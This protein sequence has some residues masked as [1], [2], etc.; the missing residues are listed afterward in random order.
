MMIGRVADEPLSC[1]F[2]TDRCEKEYECTTMVG[3]VTDWP[4]SRE[5]NVITVRKR[6]ESCRRVPPQLD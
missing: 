2:Y 6:E 4:Q 5:F 1:W 3:C